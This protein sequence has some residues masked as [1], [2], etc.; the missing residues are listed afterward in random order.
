M[1]HDPAVKAEC[2]GVINYN[3]FGRYSDVVWVFFGYPSGIV[4]DYLGEHRRKPK[5]PR[6]KSN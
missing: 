3:S 6:R 2:P 5:K 4:R 1:D